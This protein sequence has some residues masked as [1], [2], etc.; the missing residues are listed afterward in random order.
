MVSKIR[1]T[2]CISWKGQSHQTTYIVCQEG[3]FRRI[4]DSANLLLKLCDPVHLSLQQI[5]LKVTKF[6]WGGESYLN[7]PCYTYGYKACV[8]GYLKEK[9]QENNSILDHINRIQGCLWLFFSFTYLRCY[10]PLRRTLGLEK[11]A[12]WPTCF[13][14]H[15]VGLIH[16]N[17]RDTSSVLIKF[18]LY[19]NKCS[20]LLR[21][22]T[23]E[24]YNS[25]E[26]YPWIISCIEISLPLVFFY[27]FGVFGLMFFT[28]QCPHRFLT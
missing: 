18:W 14:S 15:S 26:K 27:L 9:L 3:R 12:P 24:K 1:H 23:S 8:C 13:T 10:F 11:S 6:W 22:L 7:S 25:V 2:D 17:V 21:I 28:I 16:H 20:A 19:W 4:T 5:A